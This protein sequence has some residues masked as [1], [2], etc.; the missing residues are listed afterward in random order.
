MKNI[1]V[2]S[3]TNFKSPQQYCW[4]GFLRYEHF[5][6]CQ[7]FKLETDRTKNMYTIILESY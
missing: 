7:N 5:K 2:N 4:R 3:L 1:Y 6:K